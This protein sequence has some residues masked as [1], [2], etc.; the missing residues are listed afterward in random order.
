MKRHVQL[1]GEFAEYIYL[2]RF[3]ISFGVW[4]SEKTVD[5]VRHVLKQRKLLS[6]MEWIQNIL[7]I[8][9]GSL[10]C[11]DLASFFQITYVATKKYQ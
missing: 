10:T 8:F 9:S 11:F 6:K 4:L 5:R 3:N 7:N 2:T 1:D